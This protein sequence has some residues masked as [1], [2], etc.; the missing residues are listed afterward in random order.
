MTAQQKLIKIYTDA[1]KNL[2][3]IIVKKEARGS[4]AHYQRSLLRQVTAEIERIKALSP[5]LAKEVVSEAYRKGLAS[6]L[7]DLESQD[8]H[9]TLGAFS[10]VDRRQ[11]RIIAQNMVDSLND[12]VNIVARRTFDAIR[13]AGLNAT[14][15][16]LSTGHTIKAMKKELI[17]SLVNVDPHSKDGRIGIE[18]KNGTVMP[19]DAYAEM[20]TRSTVAETQN[21]SKFNQSLAW[22]YDLVRCTKH[23]PTCEVCAKYQD[24]TYAL[25]KEAANGKYK[26][27][28]GEPLYFPLLFETALVR[29]YD[30]IHPNCIHGFYIV[31]A[32]AEDPADLAEMSRQSMEPFEDTRSDNERKMYAVGQT[33]KRK[34]RQDFNHWN[35]LKAVLPDDTPSSFGA[36]R[37]M[38]S[39]NSERYRQLLTDYRY[40]MKEMRKSQ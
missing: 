39:H 17:A 3:D 16:K 8:T 27:P 38:K 29:G 36:F 1:Q 33:I 13:E 2:Y 23:Y 31:V 18:Y 28:K 20:V 24:R 32:T 35:R 9:R 30:I 11:I 19:L 34:R 5:A 26:G 25:T 40:V 4:V 7:R 21:R 14:A 6:L 37:N 15:A 10:Y 22:G 12:A